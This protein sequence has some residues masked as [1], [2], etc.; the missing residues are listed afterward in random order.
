MGFF[1]NDG[2]INCFHCYTSIAIAAKPVL[3]RYSHGIIDKK[4]T[5]LRFGV[6]GN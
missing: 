4:N 2:R 5:M 3:W 1:T 6:K